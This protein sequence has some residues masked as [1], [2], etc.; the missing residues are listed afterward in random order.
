MFPTTTD[1]I[2]RTIKRRY[3]LIPYL[4]SLALESHTTAS[5]P[6]RWTGW[7][8]ES[9]P[10]VW[11][12]PT[13]T[14]GET[15]YWLGDSILIG[16]VYE[17]GVS[18]SRI[19]LPKGADGNDT[20]MQYLNLNAPYQYLSSG[21]WHD[22]DSKWDES[23]PVIAK[24]GGAVPVGRPC[25]TLSAGEDTNRAELP[26][27]EYRA[28][29][30]FPGLG[31]SGER[32]YSNSWYEDDGISPAPA[33]ISTFVISYGWSETEI[34]VAFEQRLQEGYSPTWKGLSIILPAGDKRDVYFG[35]HTMAFIC[36]DER[37]RRVFGSQDRCVSKL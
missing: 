9:D 20:A 27:D 36:M 26:A 6:Q 32:A 7:G 22:I 1:I 33:K 17:P 8:Y 12:S 34:R 37:S 10:E 28:V 31:N 4:Y 35:G 14:D 5:P 13:L 11:N 2:R 19:Y 15:Q 18:S 23:I 3:E 30:I 29:E 25:Q 16:G 24:V 21:E